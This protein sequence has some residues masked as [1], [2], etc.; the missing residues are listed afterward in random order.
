MTRKGLKLSQGQSET[1]KRLHDLKIMSWNINDI[2]LKNEGSKSCNPD[3]IKV[4]EGTDIICFQETKEPIKILNYR[5]YNSN[6]RDSRSG[7]VCIA[8]KNQ[9]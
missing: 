4:I 2:K 3:F 5:C 1:S 7:G 6:R 8:I 9:I